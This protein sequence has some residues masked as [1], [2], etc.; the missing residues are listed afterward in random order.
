MMT[1]RPAKPTVPPMINAS[2]LGVFMRCDRTTA[3][4]RLDRWS[5]KKVPTGEKRNCQVLYITTQVLQA[6]RDNCSDE[7]AD[8]FKEWLRGETSIGSE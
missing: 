1:G 8:L 3:V 4:R 6:L 2:E 5:V 7:V